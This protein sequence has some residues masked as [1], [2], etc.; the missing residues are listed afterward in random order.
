MI[1]AAGSF[2]WPKAVYQYL[3]A[4]NSLSIQTVRAVVAI[5]EDGIQNDAELVDIDFR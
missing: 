3:V 1:R 5:G 4:K 2:F